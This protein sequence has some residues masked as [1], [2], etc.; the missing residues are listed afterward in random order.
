MKKRLKYSHIFYI[1]FA[2][3]ILNIIP[4]IIFQNQIQISTNSIATIA[5]A[6]IVIL[7]G[8]LAYSFK[9]KGNFLMINRYRH[10]GFSEDKDYT[11]T[12]E[13]EREFRWMLLIYCLPI[14]FYLPV[15]F[16]ATSW[17]HTIWALILYI[18]PQ[19]I[20]VIHGIY[21]TVQMVKETKRREAQ[22]Q[23]ER[24]EQEKREELGYWK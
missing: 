23:K 19:V 8:V 6:G 1:T 18:A 5:L 3:F 20:Y 2:L 15:I 13:Y 22:L 14:P 12:D 4:L 24:E 10:T 21:Q 7:Q 17:K 11:F 16:F 9:H